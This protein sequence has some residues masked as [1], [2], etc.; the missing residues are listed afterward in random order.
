MPAWERNDARWIECSV[1]ASF[2]IAPIAVISGVAALL[3]IA[4]VNARMP[5]FGLS[6]EHGSTPSEGNAD[7]MPSS[8]NGCV[9]VAW[10]PITL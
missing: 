1:S 10:L 4:A 6:M 8:I 7:G 5:V 9:A 2:M 3:A